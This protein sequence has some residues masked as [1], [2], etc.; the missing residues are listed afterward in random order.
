MIRKVLVV[1]LLCTSVSILAQ[2][3][4]AS[5][6]SFFGIGEEFSART[7][8]QNAMGGIGVAFSHYKY[9]NFTNP[10]AFA[11]LRY[12]T[13]TLGLLNNELTLKTDATSQSG[14]TTRLSYVALAFPLGKKAGMS[15]GMQPVSSIGYNLSNSVFDSD[16]GITELTRFEGTGGV[17]RVYGSLGFKLLPELSLGLEADFMFGNVDNSVINRRLGVSLGTKYEDISTVR[18]GSIKLGAHY[19]KELKNKL[20]V[21]AGATIK[22]AN[23]LNVEGEDYLYSVSFSSLG[24]EIPRDTISNNPITGS[25]NLPMQTNLGIGVGKTDKWYAGVEYEN[26]QAIA[27]TGLLASNTG[28]FRYG[29]SSRLSVG[30]YF[31]PKI[32]SI[33]SY[34]ERV[35]YRAG[36]R[37]E[38]TGLL[39][40]GT[41]NN[42]NFTQ[43]DDFGITFG[44]GLPLKGLSTVNLGFE[45]GQRG[46]INNSLIQENY[47]NI[48]ISMSLTDTR[49][50]FKREID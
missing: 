35:T 19:K 25:Y 2:R 44:L 15:F 48:R 39:I 42:S 34:W 8:E 32:N 37:I 49:W 14:S 4:T 16:G 43:I 38:N 6:Y 13:Y 18:G 1:L 27:T 50:F 20:N 31:L 26:Q 7:V 21:N 45:Y 33:S 11:D 22:L 10:A 3:T 28:A 24:S 40:D 9:I 23:E 46:T 47:F 12:T 17:N 30:G 36:L 5:P 41:G 29:N